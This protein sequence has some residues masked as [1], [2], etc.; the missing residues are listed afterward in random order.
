MGG[1]SVVIVSW[2]ARDHLRECLSSVRKTADATVKE[3]IVIDNAS[4]DGSSEMV[5]AEFR[6]VTLIRATENLGFARANNVALERATGTWLA[7]INSDVVVHPNCFQQL[8]NYLE[9]HDETGLVG[10]KLYGVDGEIQR[11]CRRL[12]TI[13]NT[14][15]RVFGLDN[16]LSRWPLFSGRE[17]RHWNHDEQAE[18]EVISG[19]FWLARRDAIQEVG[20]LDE[21]F[22][23]YSEDV[24][25]CR[26]FRDAGWKMVFVPNA[27]A[28]HFGGG[29][30]ANAPFRYSVEMLRANLA[31]WKKHRGVVTV[32]LFY[33][34]CVLH[35]ALRLSARGMIMLTSRSKRSEAALKFKLS[36]VCLHWLITRSEPERG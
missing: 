16:V 22:F 29:S 4:S 5:A 23:F 34:L 9:S 28:M 21:R 26:R 6:D 27:T 24:D 8:V 25:W 1:I 20:T 31:Y 7:L 32:G 35:H 19:C 17:M 2:N 13:W 33:A 12:P 30:S 36:Q 3:I 11:S 10:P 15:C 18:V 14:I